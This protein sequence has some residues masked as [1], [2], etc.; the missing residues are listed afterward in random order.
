MHVSIYDA[1][2]VGNLTEMENISAA[3]FGAEHTKIQNVAY[4]TSTE[5]IEREPTHL[6]ITSMSSQRVYLRPRLVFANNRITVLS[7]LSDHAGSGTL[8]PVNKFYIA[9]EKE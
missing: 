8:S 3:L 9:F 7:A 5:G 4:W 2:E 6:I 1:D